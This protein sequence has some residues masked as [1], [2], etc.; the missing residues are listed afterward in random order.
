MNFFVFR[1]KKLIKFK[2][3]HEVELQSKTNKEKSTE[4]FPPRL[5]KPKYICALRMC[6]AESKKRS[7]KGSN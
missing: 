2:L 4:M 5:L 7:A 1:F 3:I 6:I